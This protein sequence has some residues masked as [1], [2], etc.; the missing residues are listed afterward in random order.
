MR[1]GDRILVSLNK[2]SDPATVTLPEYCQCGSPEDSCYMY[3]L[4]ATN[5][6]MHKMYVYKPFRF[7]SNIVECHLLLL[8]RWINW[9]PT[10]NNAFSFASGICLKL[11]SITCMEVM[12]VYEYNY[13]RMGC[14]AESC[15]FWINIEL[16]TY[17]NL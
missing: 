13:I 17:I 7:Y 3:L 15:T 5:K 8:R 6:T 16:F 14:T 1:I 2:L 9:I 11:W 4:C 10:L 12:A